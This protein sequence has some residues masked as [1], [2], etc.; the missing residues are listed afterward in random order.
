MKKILILFSFL[1]LVLSAPAFALEIDVQGVGRVEITSDVVTVQAQA[2]TQALE[3]AIYIAV[4]KTLGADTTLK[5]NIARKMQSII[6]QIDT[7]KITDNYASKREGNTYVLTAVIKLDDKKFRQLV[8]DMGIAVNTARARAAGA[9]MVIMDEYFTTPTDMKAPLKDLTEFSSESTSKHKEMEA[10]SAKHKKA[11]G[12]SASYSGREGVSARNGYGGS[13]DRGTAV[14]ARASS[15]SMEKGSLDYARGESDFKHEKVNF[16]RLVEYQPKNPMPDKQNYTMN[17]FKKQLQEL[18]LKV[19]ADNIFKSKYFKKPMTIEQMQNSEALAKYAMFARK[20]A[21]AD[22]LSVG[23]AIIVDNGRDGQTGQYICDGMITLSTYA[24]EG[25]EDIAADSVTESAL[26]GSSD[27]CRTSVA[28]K[29]GERL[30][31]VLGKN[32]QEYWKRRSMYGREYAIIL[33]GKFPLATRITFKKALQ[34]TPGIEGVE[35]K[36][37]E[38]SDA[39]YTVTYKGSGQALDA[40]AENLMAVPIFA[41]LD[42]V[43]LGNKI[44]FCTGKCQASD[45]KSSAAAEP[46]AKKGKK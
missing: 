20:D 44:T 19:I 40:I 31:Q 14:D 10:L 21:K 16:K 9:M 24:T 26:G 12:S 45:S 37:A 32:V 13:Y 3:N 8:S 25:G 5:E 30:G 22:F 38:G 23:T 29:M 11:E 28:S 15:A 33:K 2:K 34:S 36:D 6:S 46:K 43:T 7:F 18:D 41:N 27:Q 4:E 39:E 1:I 17:A 35:Q 42:A